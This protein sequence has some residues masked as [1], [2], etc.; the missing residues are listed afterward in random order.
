M[1]AQ[2]R[3]RRIRHFVSARWG[4]P[5]TVAIS[6]TARGTAMLIGRNGRGGSAF[7]TTGAGSVRRVILFVSEETDLTGAGMVLLRIIKGL[8]R[9]RFTPV[10]FVHEANQRLVRHVVQLGVPSVAS[11]AFGDLVAQRALESGAGVRKMAA[12]LRIIGRLTPQLVRCIRQHRVDLVHANAYPMALYCA[13]ACLLTNTPFI[14]HEHSLRSVRPHNWLNYWLVGR[15]A[16]RTIAV[17]EACKRNLLSAIP[18]SK[19]AV[20]RNG[21]DPTAVEPDAADRVRAEFG[22]GP[23]E[24]L[25]ALVGQPRE[26]KGAH[27][28][29]EAAAEIVR[30]QP[31]TRLLVVGYLF[32]EDAYQQRLYRLVRSLGLERH[33]IFTGWRED[34]P[35][36]MWAIDM[37]VHCRL[38]PEPAALVLIEAMAAGKPVVV[39]DTGGSREI[40]LHGV[41]GLLYPPGD[42]KA[43]ARSVLDLLRHPEK[44]KAM[45]VAGRRRVDELFTMDRQVQQ[46][47]E[48]YTE[49]AR[50]RGKE[51][52][53]PEPLTKQ[54]E[55][56]RALDRVQGE[57]PE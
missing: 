51:S 26:E 7:R 49:I 2:T 46:F 18:S 31:S 56:G 9:S 1:S 50:F 55:K 54:G 11:D 37:L 28:Y 12:R 15:T 57:G 16:A 8:D 53:G 23:G 19:I 41:T 34:I 14:F 30:E 36:I 33:V 4:V 17:S 47:Q 13:P 5:E 39:S 44:L 29:I 20:I 27:V 48:V 35:V 25:L 22:V 3:W 6:S 40:V 32:E 52:R 43:L 45:G 24:F 10:V 21:V 38:T 42:A